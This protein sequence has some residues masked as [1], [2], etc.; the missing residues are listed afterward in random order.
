MKKISLILLLFI[1]T[2]VV[3]AQEDETSSTEGMQETT[4]MGTETEVE[5]ESVTEAETV[6]TEA[7]AEYDDPDTYMVQVAAY[8]DRVAPAYFKSMGVE[9]VFEQVELNTLYKYYMGPYETRVEAQEVQSRI[10]GQGF[11]YARVINMTE[12][13]DLCSNSCETAS[14]MTS[15][16]VYSKDQI[17]KVK[18]VFFEFDSSTLNAKGKEE[19]KKLAVILKGNAGY[20]VEVHAH[21]DSKG[22]DD[23]N[24]ALSDR[25]KNVVVNYL[26]YQKV[27]PFQ[28]QSFAYGE[29]KP[30]A[31]NEKNGIDSPAG[32][33]YNRRVELVV[34]D[35]FKKVDVVEDIEIPDGLRKID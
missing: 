21:T 23:Y 15:V 2:L 19:M 12:I 35:Q 31:L 24:L 6:S 27:P 7:S 29:A 25:R 5:T 34:K 20:L 1:S 4:E 18:N 26:K 8:G 3:S 17:I 16:L 9:G 13:A 30:I 11:P 22:S 28:I 10:V 32:R 14:P 33:A